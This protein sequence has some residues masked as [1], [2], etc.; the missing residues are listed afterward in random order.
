MQ[1]LVDVRL[2]RRLQPGQKRQDVAEL[3]PLAPRRQALAH[4][5]VEGDQADR[6]LLVDHQVA[7]G[8]RQADAVL[9]LRQLLAVSVAH[10]AGEVHHQIAG[11]VGL[12]LELLDVE[13][14][15]LGV[16]VPVDVG[17]VVA[18]RVLAVLGKLDRE[19]LERAGVQPGDEAL[20]DELGAQVEPGDLADHLGLQVFFGGAGQG[21]VLRRQTAR[22]PCYVTRSDRRF[23]PTKP[24]RHRALHF[25]RRRPCRRGGRTWASRAHGSRL[26]SRL[27]RLSVDL[28]FGLGLEVG[29]DSVPEH[30]DGHL[31]DVVERHAEPAVHRRHRLAGQDQVL[32]GARPGAVV[33]QVLDELGRLLVGRA[34][35]P[36]PAASR[37]RPCIPR[38]APR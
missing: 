17:D 8:R 36:A 26:I 12:G 2:A 28:T 10:R 4:L 18:G 11:Q 35:S 32:A 38:P 23:G 20:D 15:G 3:R 24:A 27:T 6:V 29:A 30:R 5:L 37:N 14:V 13:P 16:N 34:G 33:D 21:N 7:E 19:P 31:A 1:A 25:G 22:A 9:E